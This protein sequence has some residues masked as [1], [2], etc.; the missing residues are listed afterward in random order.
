M[1]R[2]YPCGLC[3]KSMKIDFD[4]LSSILYYLDKKNPYF[5][6]ESEKE[7]AQKLVI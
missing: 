5:E 6:Y 3:D 4:W 1:T 7:M 2:K